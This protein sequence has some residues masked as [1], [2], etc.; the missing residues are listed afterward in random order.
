MRKNY[1]KNMIYKAWFSRFLR[2]LTRKRSGSILTTTE[3]HGANQ[4]DY[5]VT[6]TC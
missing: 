1:T 6:Y 3:K 4:V 5:A 2:H